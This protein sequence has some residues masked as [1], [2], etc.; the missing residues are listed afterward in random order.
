LPEFATLKAMGYSNR[1]FVWV[2]LQESVLLSLMGFLPGVVM[3]EIICKIVAWLTNLRVDVHTP[4]AV[5]VLVMSIMMCV[6]SGLVAVRRV[7][8]VDPAE[9]F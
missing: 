5:A 9:L 1:Y 2:I 7:M 8:K 6:I 4:T 3:S